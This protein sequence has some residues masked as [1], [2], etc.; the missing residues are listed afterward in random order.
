MH[1]HQHANSMDLSAL[2]GGAYAGFT[3]LYTWARGER[4]GSVG[5]AI[6]NIRFCHPLLFIRNL[7]SHRLKL[8]SRLM[9]LS[10]IVWQDRG[11]DHRE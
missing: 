1:T 8:R 10:P 7:A 11:K 3:K 5:N 6:A 2:V 9:I 4:G